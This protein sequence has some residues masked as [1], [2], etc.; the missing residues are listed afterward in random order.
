MH[1]SSSGYANL[2]CT[3]LNI[4][5][6]LI[7]SVWDYQ[8]RKQAGKQIISCLFLWPSCLCNIPAVVKMHEVQRVTNP[9]E[10]YPPVS[11]GYKDV[12]QHR[13]NKEYVQYTCKK[14]YILLWRGMQSS[15]KESGVTLAY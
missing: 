13:T 9:R 1:F 11:K 15:A 4:Q 3:P 6:Y 5:P 12:W 7:S 10:G 14:V 2:F 8:Q